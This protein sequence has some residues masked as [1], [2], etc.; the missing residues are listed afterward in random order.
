MRLPV[1]CL[2]VAALLLVSCAPEPLVMR[3]VA[4]KIYNRYENEEY[5]FRIKYPANWEEKPVS[6]GMLFYCVSSI[7]IPSISVSAVSSNLTYREQVVKGLEAIGEDVEVVYEGEGK[8]ADGTQTYE[9]IV[10]WR[11]YDYHIKSFDMGLRVDGKWLSISV[12][13][14]E[15]RVLYDEDWCREVTYSLK[16]E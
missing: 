11:I 4:G 13:T 14:I 1:S 7:G 10:K 9:V 5:N 8:L 16:F 3:D 15:S 6:D 2:M 12:S